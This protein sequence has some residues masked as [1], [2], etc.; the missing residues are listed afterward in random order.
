MT[1]PEHDSTAAHRFGGGAVALRRP[2]LAAP[3]LSRPRSGIAALVAACA[4][5]AALS[6]LL[7]STPTYDPWAWILWGREIASGDLSTLT[8]PSWKPLPALFTTVF[9]LAGGAAPALW[10][11]V[12]RTGGLLALAFAFRVA[13]R[14][15][16]PL[17]GVVAVVALAVL[18]FFARAAAL[19]DSEGLLIA[20][21]LLALELHLVGRRRDALLAGFAGALLRPETWPFLGLYGLW[22]WR[23]EPER[24]RLLMGLALALPVLW[25]G[26]ELW[27]SGNAFRASARA[28]QVVPG[29][30]AT[31][32]HPPLALL[33][34]AWPTVLFPVRLA[35]IFALLHA[36]WTRRTHPRSRAVAVLGLAAVF[37]IAEVAAMTQAGYSGNMRYLLAP[38]SLVCVMGGIGFA[39]IVA[40]AGALRWRALGPAVAVALLACTA[41]YVPGPVRQLGRDADAVAKEVRI[42]DALTPAVALAGGRAGV[43]ACG[44]PTIGNLQVTALAWR[45]HVHVGDIG[46]VA[47]PRAVVFLARPAHRGAGAPVA[48]RAG[49]GYHALGSAGVWH[50]LER[51]GTRGI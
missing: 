5:L 11:V 45:L 33:G 27:G 25:L 26:P 12:A 4:A 17:A 22:L 42:N 21:T 2:R 19:G 28:Q 20:F 18:N 32:R 1:P 8:G 15:G 51:C 46:Y 9:A 6:L 49:G 48:Q 23:R 29:S 31:N 37:W 50:V 39:R 14:L 44:R 40:L 47:P 35:A 24:R 7:P 36:L 43:L 3:A 30:P 16:G 10:L 34:R 38:M 41:V 13:R